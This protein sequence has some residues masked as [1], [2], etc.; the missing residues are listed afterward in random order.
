MNKRER[1]NLLVRAGA[2]LIAVC[3]V[4]ALALPAFAADT[5]GDDTY[6]YTVRIFAGD[7]GTVDGKEVLIEENIVPG[8]EKIYRY[9]E[10]AKATDSKYYPTG[11]RESGKDNSTKSQYLGAFKV[12]K[13][14][15]LVVSYGIKGSQVAYTINYL[16]DGSTTVLHAPETYYGNVGDKPVVSYL[17]IEGYTPRYLNLTG[18]LDENAANNNWTFYYVS[19]A[20]ETEIN[21]E[22]G[23]TTT[24]TTTTTTW[25]RSRRCRSRWSYS[26][27]S[28]C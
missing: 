24:T 13:D 18:T 7:K 16:L 20:Q 17:H 8:T 28:R 26:R 5:S 22:T 23:T 11:I 6:T 10:L 25:S 15:D 27:R 9:Q 14:L 1:K 2:V 21:G 3:M 4:A 19:N 12:N